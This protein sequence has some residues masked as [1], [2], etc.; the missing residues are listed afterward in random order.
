[1]TQRVIGAKGSPRRR[2]TLLLP[3]V[4]AIALG[5]FYITGAQAVHD[6]STGMQLDGNVL[7]NCPNPP[8]LCTEAP[9][10]PHQ[11]DWEDFYDVSG[12]T[13]TVKSSL[14]TDFTKATFTRDFESG[15]NRNNC[16]L[17]STGTTFCTGDSTT[18]ATG[19]KD[20]LDITGGGWQCNR[21][22]NVNSKIDIMNAYAASYKIPV[23]QPN[24]GDT[25]LYFGLEK[26][27]DNGTNDVGFWFLQAPAS[28]SSSGPAQNFTGSPH[29]VGDVLV[30]SEFT[31]G[32]GVSNITAYR[33]V[34]GQNPLVQFASASGNGGDC[35][36][37]S[38]LDVLC[39]TTNSGA[40]PFNTTIHTPWLTSDATLGV[41]HDQIVPPD[42]FE[43]GIDVTRAFAVGGGGSAPS[44]FSTFVGD[45]RSSTSLTATLFDFAAG[46]LGGC[47]TTVTSAQTWRPN[48]SA[49]VTVTGIGSWS[50]NLK[51]TLFN[52]LNCTGTKSY[53]PA[54]IPITQAN[55]G[56]PVS[57]SNTTFD[58]TA[59]G[60]YS[61]EVDFTPSQA[62]IDAGVQ[63]PAPVCE[64]TAL[65][66]NNTATHG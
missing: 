22:N 52:S 3:L 56:L 66:I 58:V 65:T 4:A 60:N 6:L 62:S 37:A 54:A 47:A 26:N 59:T 1:M 61:W 40:H 2:W 51:F 41:G 30:V 14:P 12:G 18:F 33:W 57:T 44:C 39:A 17:T 24:A 21:D 36:T 35:K 29:T 43:G 23:G 53:D 42:F 9:T 13:T 11:V 49:T 64:S 34:G 25:V 27:K 45:T 32:G 10:T 20:T 63:D 31:S 7:N 16:S 15:T 19:S 50:G 48:D 28:C 8:G 5:L 38:G 55:N 46:Q